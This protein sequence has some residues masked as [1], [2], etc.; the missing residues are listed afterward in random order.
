MKRKR[1]AMNQQ[2]SKAQGAIQKQSASVTLVQAIGLLREEKN[3]INQ[4]LAALPAVQWLEAR[5][6]DLANREQELHITIDVLGRMFQE[7]AVGN[8]ADVCDAETRRQAGIGKAIERACMD[9]P[10]STEISVSLEKDAGTVTLIDQ[11]GNEHTNFSTDCGFAGVL[12][13]AID[14]AI[15]AM[16]AKEG[17]AA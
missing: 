11:D 14:A 1:K 12:N 8:A 3:S 5:G 7:R 15:A 2:T 17:G 4:E 6:R 13:E 10:D 9:L 16:G